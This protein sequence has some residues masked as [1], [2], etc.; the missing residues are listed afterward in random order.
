MYWKMARGSVDV[1]LSGELSEAWISV[2]VMSL[3]ATFA[4]R[5]S[6]AHYT[7]TG[8]TENMPQG[9]TENSLQGE[10][11]NSARGHRKLSARGN[12]KL[13]KEKQTTLHKNRKMSAWGKQKSLRTEET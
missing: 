7:L 6:S 11:E 3:P 2:S 4:L 12:R 9:E 1:H 10:T 5:Y 8:E 13:C